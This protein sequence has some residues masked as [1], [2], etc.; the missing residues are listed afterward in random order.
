MPSLLV[1]TSKAIPSAT[2][3]TSK[4]VPS[5]TLSTNKALPIPRNGI[6]EQDSHRMTQQNVME[7]QETGAR[8][9]ILQR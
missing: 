6:F 1:T 4:A 2:L 5:A 7:G 3:P 9:L 8:T